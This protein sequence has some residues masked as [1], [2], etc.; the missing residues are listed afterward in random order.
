MI[1]KII[2]QSTGKDDNSKS[3]WIFGY[4]SLIWKPDFPFEHCVVGHIDGFVRRFWQGSTWHRGNDQEVHYTIFLV[5]VVV[6]VGGRLYLKSCTFDA[7]LFFVF[8]PGEWSPW[9]R[10]PRYVS[11][12]FRHVRSPLIPR[13]DCSKVLH[14]REL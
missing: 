2:S 6:H 4:G 13:E 11:T 1:E 7:A 8:S 12:S 10:K 14:N 5:F 3:L 9:S